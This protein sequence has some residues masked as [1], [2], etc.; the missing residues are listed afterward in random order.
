MNDWT[1]ADVQAELHMTRLNEINFARY[2]LGEPAIGPWDV[3]NVPEHIDRILDNINRL[4]IE[5]RTIVLH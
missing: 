5:G 3:I 4:T 1:W 2:V